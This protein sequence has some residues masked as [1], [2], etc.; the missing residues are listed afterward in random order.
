MYPW[1]GVSWQLSLDHHSLQRVVQ[2]VEGVFC[3][4]QGAGGSLGHLLDLPLM[5]SALLLYI[6]PLYTSFTLQLTNGNVQCHKMYVICVTSN[7][8]N[9]NFH[10]NQFCSYF[11]AY[12]EQLDLPGKESELLEVEVILEI[13]VNWSQC[14]C[15]ITLLV[16]AD[17][18]QCKATTCKKKN[19]E[20]MIEV[21]WILLTL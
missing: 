1:R 13:D 20:N 15:H 4:K 19:F 6:L 5:Y 17:Q 10:W 11:E 7:C 16:S 8:S 3:W 9:P 14:L 18:L 21:G 2:H 12:R